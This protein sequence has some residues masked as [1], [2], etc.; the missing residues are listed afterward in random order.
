MS[1]PVTIIGHAKRLFDSPEYDLEYTPG[2]TVRDVFVQLSRH[3]GPDFARAI[4]DVKNDLMN[5]SIV[6]FVNSREIRTLCG[7]GT[8]LKD[9]DEVTLMPPMSGG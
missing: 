3:S 6:V 8:I 1:I 5:E 7:M 9:G 4:Y 2:M